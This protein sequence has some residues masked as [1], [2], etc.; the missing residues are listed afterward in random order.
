MHEIRGENKKNKGVSSIIYSN[1]S[2]IIIYPLNF[3]GDIEIFSL[4]NK[5]YFSDV[6]LISKNYFIDDILSISP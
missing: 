5:K 6:K 2:Q 1:Y 3:F 4:K